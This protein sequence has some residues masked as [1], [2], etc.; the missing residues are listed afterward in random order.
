MSG[1][2]RNRFESLLGVWTKP[3]EHLCLLNKLLQLVLVRP[4]FNVK[5]LHDWSNFDL[6]IKAYAS[7]THFLDAFLM[8]VM[9]VS[10][11]I[12]TRQDTRR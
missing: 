5:L 11:T 4:G 2:N 10:H 9:F 1:K 12:N 7:R 8:F 6:P 3:P